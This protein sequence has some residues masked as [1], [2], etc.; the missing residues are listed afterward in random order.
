MKKLYLLVISTLAL[1][2]CSQ[3]AVL[4]NESIETPSLSTEEVGLIDKSP[5]NLTSDD[6]K[7][8][9]LRFMSKGIK[10]RAPQSSAS[11]ETIYDHALGIPLLYIV[12]FENDNG[13]A[14]ISAT[15][16]EAP[17]LVY[18]ETGNYNVN[19]SDTTNEY[20]EMYKK[21]IKEAYL[22][23]SDSLRAKYALEWAMFEKTDGAGILTRSSS[24]TNQMIQDEIR[25]KTA[26]GYTYI[27]KLSAAA[28]YLSDSDYQN[29]VSDISTHSDPNYDYK[30]VTL[31]FIKSFETEKI[32]PL[33]GT[34]WHQESPFNIDAPNGFAGCVPIAIAQIAYYHKYPSKYNWNEIY[35][36]PILND[37]FKNFIL[38]IRNLCHVK[39]QD[40][41]TSATYND[42]YNTLKNLGYQVK[43]GGVPNY[44]KLRKSITYKNPVFIKGTN[45]STHKGHA[46]VCEGYHN[47]RYDASISMI[48]DRKYGF[49]EPGTPYFDYNTKAYLPDMQQIDEYFYMNMGNGG[50]L[51]GW[52]RANSYNAEHPEKSYMDNQEIITIQKPSL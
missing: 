33:M 48:I 30:E 17:V 16:K 41:G 23:S 18:S 52:Y 42:A 51:D 19:A 44:E 7:R 28:T 37:V 3:D 27:G 26:M 40:D 20:M 38:D 39:Y 8:V 6:A 22:D 15:K 13:Y 46:W 1:F 31:F 32:G 49:P 25:R 2:S 29:L 10:T 11:V 21:H 50:I 12:N 5:V 14:V 43:K 24:A 9:A 34:K 4:E 36:Y 35:N 47:I 45:N